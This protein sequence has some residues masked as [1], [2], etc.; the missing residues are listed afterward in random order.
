MKFSII[1]P[2]YN[3]ESFIKECLSS[4]FNSDLNGEVI[5]V[6]NNS[7]DNTVLLVKNNFPI[8]QIIQNRSNLGFGAAANRGALIAKGEHLFFLNPDTLIFKNSFRRLEKFIEKEKNFGVLGLSLVNEKKT[9]SI[10]SFGRK[11]DLLQILKNKFLKPKKIFPSGP[12]MT[13]WVSGA[14]FIVP[15]KIFK[16]VGGFD[17]EFF[18]YFEDQNLCLRI[19]SLGYPIYFLPNIQVVHLGGKTW[20]SSQDKKKHYY[21]SQDYFFKKHF[22][23]IQYFLMKFF[24]A[25][26]KWINTRK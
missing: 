2:T 21:Q 6:D 22:G 7:K 23:K 4:I 14:A 26:L 16:Q 12:V 17:E 25:P 20:K 10:F 8:V 15:K 1:I 13:D 18:M 24:R 9:P 19:K 11:T 3:T 5:V